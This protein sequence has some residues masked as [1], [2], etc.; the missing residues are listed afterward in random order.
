MPKVWVSTKDIDKIKLV[1]EKFPDVDRF[2]L[3]EHSQSGIGSCL[4]MIFDTEVN[5]T[6]CKMTVPIADESTW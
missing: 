5:N 1:L 4:D 6:K 2:V 3:N